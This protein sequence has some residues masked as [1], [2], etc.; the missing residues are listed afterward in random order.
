M[1]IIK[2]LHMSRNKHLSF[3]MFDFVLGAYTTLEIV[4]CLPEI[5]SRSGVNVNENKG[6]IFMTSHVIFN[7][8]KVNDN[9]KPKRL[10][11]LGK[12]VLIFRYLMFAIM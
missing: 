2:N 12:Y 1:S 7:G 10:E 3:H 11:T 5:W 4:Y 8:L 9:P 6:D